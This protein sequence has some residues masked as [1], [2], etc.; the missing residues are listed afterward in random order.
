[1]KYIIRVHIVNYRDDSHLETNRNDLFEFCR[2]FHI[3]QPRLSRLPG[4]DC[5]EIDPNSMSERR[6]FYCLQAL[7]ML[8]IM[9]P[10]FVYE[11]GEVDDDYFSVP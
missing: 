8:E 3:P 4:G 5:W 10:Y 6:S 2:I 9:N 1:M 7:R 11:T